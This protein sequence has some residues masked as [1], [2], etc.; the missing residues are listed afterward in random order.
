MEVDV[1]QWQMLSDYTHN[2]GP[3]KFSSEW[4]QESSICANTRQTTK[5]I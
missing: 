5:H 2:M 3:K 4:G 1:K